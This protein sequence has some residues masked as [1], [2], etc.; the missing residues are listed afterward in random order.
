MSRTH[1]MAA[2]FKLACSIPAD[3]FEIPDM[4]IGPFPSITFAIEAHLVSPTSSEFLCRRIPPRVFTDRPFEFELSAVRLGAGA[5]A[6]VSVASWISAHAH[7]QISVEVPGQPRGE[8]SVLVQARPFGGGW[9][10][11]GLTR[12]AA[13]A[14]AATVTVV[15]LSLAGRPLSCDCLPVILR[16]GYN[17][18]PGPAG[19]VLRAAFDG[20]APVLQATLDAGG[21][22]EETDEV[23]AC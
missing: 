2:A 21:S 17:H 11:R 9:S 6:A 8:V 1:V 14:D 13:W 3:P 15:S 10:V 5:S 18:T 16:V 22:T 23:R 7:L 20:D 4:T 12:P 19:A